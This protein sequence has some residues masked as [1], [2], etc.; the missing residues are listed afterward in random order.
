M[1]P[2][3]NR[4]INQA[5]ILC[6]GMGLR[7]G[8]LTKDLPKPLVPLLGRPVLDYIIENLKK[9]GIT[10]FVLSA[11]YMADKIVEY[12]EK[13]P[14]DGC[15][16]EVVIEPK[17]LGTAGGV[18]FCR[19]HLDDNFMVVYGDVLVDCDLT[20]LIE[21]HLARRPIGTLLLWESD[22]ISDP[23]THIIEMEAD[24]RISEIVTTR[25]PEKIY[26]NRCNAAVYVLNKR[27]LR[28][29]SPL[30]LPLD[31]SRDIFPDVIDGAFQLNG[32]MMEETGFIKDM[33][34]PERL[35][36]AEAYLKTKL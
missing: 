18:L 25:D 14:V 4:P 12:Y 17:P 35:L 29:I 31:F 30:A 10:K 8:E 34:T 26:P 36:E 7:L 6:G 3:L 5:V 13:N 15:E 1:V 2:E 20:A 21:S 24:G 33:G 16:I 11:G 27:I 22:Y 19:K 9:H 23:H 28:Y 32:H